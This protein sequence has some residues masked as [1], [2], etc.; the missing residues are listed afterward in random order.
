M[1][2]D[3]LPILFSKD[4][5][6]YELFCISILL[7]NTTWHEMHAKISDFSK[8]SVGCATL[9]FWKKYVLEMYASTIYQ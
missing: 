3:F 4:N 2:I 1:E 6:L 5:I 8:V 7:F 9:T